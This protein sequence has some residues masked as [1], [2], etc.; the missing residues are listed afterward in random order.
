MIKYLKEHGNKAIQEAIFGIDRYYLNSEH[1]DIIPELQEVVKDNKYNKAG[2]DVVIL[3]SAPQTIYLIDHSNQEEFEI[4][5]K[6][7]RHGVGIRNVYKL[8]NLT[9]DDL[10]EIIRNL[11]P[12]YDYS[13][14]RISHALQ[15]AG[16]T[17][18]HL[19]GISIDDE[20]K[21]I[22]DSNV[23][24]YGKD[25]RNWPTGGYGSGRYDYNSSKYGRTTEGN[26]GE[27]VQQKDNAGTGLTISTIQDWRDALS[28]FTTPQGEVYAFAAP[29]G[30]LYF[31][32]TVISSEHPIHEYTHLWDRVVAKNNPQLWQR[33]RNFSMERSRG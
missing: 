13:A 14:R 17:E 2:T 26:L 11:S 12:K 30:N 31:D 27:E 15:T 8:D 3:N 25:R 6:E 28:K 18:E 19:L 4:H 21:R 23:V 9:E 24:L 33:E 10:K 7:G 22:I 16:L 29:N 32:E 20:L 5:K 1:L